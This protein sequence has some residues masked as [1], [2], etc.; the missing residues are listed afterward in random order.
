MQHGPKERIPE[1]HYK[2]LL[3]AFKSFVTINHL[4]GMSWACQHKKLALVLRT[5]LPERRKARNF[6]KRV[7]HNTAVNFRANKGKNKEESQIHW[8]T[9]KNLLLWFNNWE[10]VS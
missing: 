7:L 2:N 8:T 5:M 1:L 6:L 4:N 10:L 9:Y 3:M